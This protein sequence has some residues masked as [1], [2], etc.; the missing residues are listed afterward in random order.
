MALKRSATN[1]ILGGD[2]VPVE[3]GAGTYFL[4]VESAG[5]T[6]P[7]ITG[8]YVAFTGSLYVNTL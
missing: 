5:F 4:E 3:L 2:S 1:E 8:T 6:S 7:S